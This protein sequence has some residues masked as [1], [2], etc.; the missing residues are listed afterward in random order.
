M[1]ALAAVLL[2]ACSTVQAE[3]LNV[4]Y[5]SADRIEL[6]GQTVEWSELG[7]PLLTPVDFH[8]PEP[9]QGIFGNP[10][11]F[12]EHVPLYSEYDPDNLDFRI[13]MG[14][15]Q[16]GRIFVAAEFQDD[17]VRDDP[18]PLFVRSDGIALSVTPQDREG[19]RQYY[20]VRPSWIKPM[21][22]VGNDEVWST[23]APFSLGAWSD[24]TPTSWAVEFFVT[25]F[26]VMAGPDDSII[27]ELAAG[28]QINLTLSVRDWDVDDVQRT[29]FVQDASPVRIRLLSPEATAVR[30]QTWGQIKAL[31]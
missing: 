9:R 8:I 6:D 1:K 27:T 22:Y 29:N 14:W 31:R 15:D 19:D 21:P 3:P 12:R 18:T 30:Q 11:T 2:L 24:T 10:N 16:P 28:D 26:D 7:P 23:L 25:V 20:A 13:W 17:F 5:V 4:P